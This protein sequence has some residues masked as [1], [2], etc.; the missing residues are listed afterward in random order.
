MARHTS[1]N[2]MGSVLPVAEAI[3]R[4]VFLFASAVLTEVAP[5]EALPSLLLTRVPGGGTAASLTGPTSLQGYAS[6]ATTAH[7]Q[8][9]A[10]ATPISKVSVERADGD[11]PFT[12][13]AL[14]A[15]SR[16]SYDDGGL[17]PFTPYRYRIRGLTSSS[18]YTDYSNEVTVTTFAPTLTTPVQLPD[19]AVPSPLYPV[20]PAVT[21][22]GVAYFAGDDLVGSQQ[23]YRPA[24]GTP[25]GTYPLTTFGTANMTGRYYPT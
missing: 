7:L 3:E 19:V 21:M 5:T 13:V 1:R 17:A 18:E 8:W 2:R 12:E 24:D 14:L 22:G 10:S 16:L 4:R 20:G 6:Y 15:K 9:T 23:L 11:G 25:G